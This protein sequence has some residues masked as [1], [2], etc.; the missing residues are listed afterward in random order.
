MLIFF[1]YKQVFNIIDYLHIFNRTLYIRTEI[2][3]SS[4]QKYQL[5]LRILQIIQNK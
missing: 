4:E 3:D 1:I 5:Y 2:Y